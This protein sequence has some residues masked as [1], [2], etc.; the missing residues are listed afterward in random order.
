MKTEE[1]RKKDVKVLREQAH[2]LKK[3][4]SDMRFK[5]AANQVKN[6]KEASNTRKEIARILTIIKEL[7]ASGEIK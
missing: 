4:L 5:L 2:D 6:V 3:K 7:S 1:L